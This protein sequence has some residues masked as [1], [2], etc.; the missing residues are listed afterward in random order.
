MLSVGLF[1]VAG[2]ELRASWLEP[3]TLWHMQ[4]GMGPDGT[5]PFLCEITGYLLAP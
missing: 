2:S 3:A 5:L 4:S 1:A